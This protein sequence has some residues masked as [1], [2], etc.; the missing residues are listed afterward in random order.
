M[1]VSSY[2]VGKML[3][4]NFVVSTNGWVSVNVESFAC[5]NGLGRGRERDEVVTSYV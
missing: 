3:S 5:E 1:Y 4:I 2:M